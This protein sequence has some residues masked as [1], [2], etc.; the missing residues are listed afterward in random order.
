V[1][2]HEVRRVAHVAHAATRRVDL[3]QA[4]A[5]CVSVCRSASVC[6]GGMKERAALA[7][8]ETS[9]THCW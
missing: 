9:T 6:L 5:P 1:L 4:S 2:Q 7:L 3:G 8:R